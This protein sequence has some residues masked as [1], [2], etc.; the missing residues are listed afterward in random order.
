MANAFISFQG[1]QIRIMFAA[2]TGCGQ[3]RLPRC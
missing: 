1:D 3:L 2:Q